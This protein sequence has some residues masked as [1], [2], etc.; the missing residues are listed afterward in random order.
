VSWLLDTNIVS[1]LRKGERAH[2]GLRAWFEEAD[3]ASLYTSV[4]VVGA[5][6][7]GIESLCRRDVPSALALEQ[8]RCSTRPPE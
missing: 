3:E 5:L 8:F 4:L 2:A 6:R 7:R 1:E